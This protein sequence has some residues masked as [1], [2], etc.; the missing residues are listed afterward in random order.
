MIAFIFILAN[1]SEIDT[2]K[3]DLLVSTI[4]FDE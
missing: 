3:C 4:K 1:L 2:E